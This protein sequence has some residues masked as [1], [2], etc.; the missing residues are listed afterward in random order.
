MSGRRAR[1][2]KERLAANVVR[3]R[4]QRE[5]KQTELATKARVTQALISAIEL[6]TANPTLESL[7]RIAQALDVE[8]AD[9]FAADATE[10]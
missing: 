10:S 1:R 2:A 5:M 7:Y 6:A 9:L 4:R 3:L 8:L